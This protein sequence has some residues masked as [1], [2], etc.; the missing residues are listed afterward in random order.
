M[1]LQFDC[2]NFIE[3]WGMAK[4]HSQGQRAL[5][6]QHLTVSWEETFMGESERISQLMGSFFCCLSNM[7]KIIVFVLF[8]L[9]CLFSNASQIPAWFLGAGKPNSKITPHWKIYGVIA[10]IIWIT[11]LFLANILLWKRTIFCSFF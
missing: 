11:L 7:N 5:C 8:I 1:F 9:G 4:K 2:L 6:Q 3:I 10:V